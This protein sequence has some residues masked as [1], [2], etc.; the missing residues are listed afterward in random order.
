MLLWF[1]ES[2]EIK[3]LYNF[4][5]FF[6]INKSFKILMSKFGRTFTGL[7]AVVKSDDGSYMIYFCSINSHPLAY[8][9]NSPIQ[10]NPSC[11]LFQPKVIFIYSLKKN[12]FVLYIRKEIPMY[13]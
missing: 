12:S 3:L 1:K 4:L 8:D 7:Y 9:T 13:Q 5:F 2:K 6:S 10:L 11:L